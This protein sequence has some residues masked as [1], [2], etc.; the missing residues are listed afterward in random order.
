MSSARATAPVFV[1]GSPRSGT[2]LLYHML[3]STGDFVN[4]RTETHVFNTLAPYAG[5]LSHRANRERLLDLWLGGVMLRLSGLEAAAVRDR[6]DDFHD[7]G[8][9]L[10]LVMEMMAE[11]QG[12]AR[13]AESTPAHLL[14]LE[15]I[16]RSLPD[17]VFLHVIRDG[18]DVALSLEKQGWIHP[19]PGDHRRAAFAA[20]AAWEWMVLEGARQGA[21]LG[22]AYRVVRYEDLVERPEATLADVGGFIGHDLRYDRILAG[23]VGSVA[24][25]NTSFPQAG[26]GFVGRWRRS[27]ETAEARALEGALARGLDR[28]GYPHEVPAAG[29]RAWTRLYHVYY[30]LRQWAK[31]RTPLGRRLADASLFAADVPDAY[32][33]D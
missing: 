24:R 19:L 8:S 17:A 32:A 9:F 18:R 4:Y 3:L 20:A 15:Q 29:S 2:T 33:G 10:R 11:R 28:Y 22:P 12:V 23:G 16:H 25:P 27:L 6:V 31:R 1:V 30:G 26:G 21:R 7:A 14:H 13:W 5:D